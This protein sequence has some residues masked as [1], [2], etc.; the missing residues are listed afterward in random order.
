MIAPSTPEEFAGILR[1]QVD[2]LAKIVRDAG[3]EVR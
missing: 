1:T 3:I 2:A